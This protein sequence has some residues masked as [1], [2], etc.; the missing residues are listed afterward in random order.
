MGV[1]LRMFDK[2][3]TLTEGG[4]ARTIETIMFQIYQRM[5]NGFQVGYSAAVAYLLLLLTLIIVNRIA[6]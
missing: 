1:H 2:A 4:P 3:I 5:F 6:F